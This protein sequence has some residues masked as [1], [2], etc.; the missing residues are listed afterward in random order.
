M[1]PYRAHLQ[2]Y[3]SEEWR[4]NDFFT[5]IFNLTSRLS[6]P[7][8]ASLSPLSSSALRRPILLRWRP[9]PLRLQGHPAAPAELFIQAWGWSG[10]LAPMP[11]QAHP[12]PRRRSS[13]AAPV[14]LLLPDPRVELEEG[15]QVWEMEVLNTDTGCSARRGWQCRPSELVVHRSQGV[16]SG[17]GSWCRWPADERRSSSLACY[18][19]RRSIKWRAWRPQPEPPVRASRWIWRTPGGFGGPTLLQP[20]AHIT[21]VRGFR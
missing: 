16:E 21:G 12:T 9:D 7:S 4:W 3:W 15:R 14:K 19:D 5:L 20:V 10:K 1:T 17:D 2:T 18:W 6:D 11:R 8:G 13:P